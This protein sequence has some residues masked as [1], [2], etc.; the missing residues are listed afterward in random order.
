MLYLYDYN[1][2]LINVISVWNNGCLGYNGVIEEHL[3]NSDKNILFNYIK[4]NVK[5]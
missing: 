3:D 5:G 2:K 4:N 1:D